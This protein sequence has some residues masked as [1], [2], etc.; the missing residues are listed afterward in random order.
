[1]KLTD[2][3]IRLVRDVCISHVLSRDQILALN[4]FSSISRANRRLS[5]LVQDRYLKV[6]DVPFQHQR[7]FIAGPKASDIVGSRIA[8]LVRS[9]AGTPRFLQHALAVTNVRIAITEN[10]VS[11]WRF[12]AQIRDQFVHG[13][14]RFQIRPDGALLTESAIQFIEAD[15]GHVSSSKFAEKISGY[16]RYLESG[17]FQTVYGHRVGTVLVITTGKLRLFHLIS[18]ISASRRACFEFKTYEELSTATFGG[19]S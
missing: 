10:E 11:E 12:E 2:R 6:H 9:R 15:L 7:L 19:W 8:S 18:V 3:D 14:R 16:Y 1:M 13:S 5:L 17:R 4:Y